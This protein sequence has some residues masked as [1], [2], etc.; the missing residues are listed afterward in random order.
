MDDFLYSCNIYSFW[1]S[2]D[3]N[4][5]SGPCTTTRNKNN[6]TGKCIN[7]LQNVGEIKSEH[8]AL[9]FVVDEMNTYKFEGWSSSREKEYHRS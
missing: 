3:T 8:V 1:S 2:I 7:G 6:F 5:S 4:I 9:H